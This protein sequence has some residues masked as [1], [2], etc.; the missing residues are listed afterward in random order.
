[1]PAHPSPKRPLTRRLTPSQ[2][3]ALLFVLEAHEEASARNL[4][5]CQFAVELEA[6]ERGGVTVNDLRALLEDGHLE[7]RLETTDRR[8]SRRTFQRVRSTALF[9][10]SCF[11]L[12]PAGLRC[13]T[14]I[15]SEP[16][17][18]SADPAPSA[19]RSGESV[20]LPVPFW[21]TQEKILWYDNR[22]LKRYLRPAP[23]QEAILREFQRKKWKH[24]VKNP[25]PR[26]HRMNPKTRLCDTLKHLNLR[27]D[28]HVLRFHSTDCGHFVTWS[29]TEAFSATR[30]ASVQ[31]ASTT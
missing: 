2:R 19:S 22:A 4:A 11:I 20:T 3:T 16:S 13:A 15:Q 24:R 29:R 26:A 10:R 21:D 27:P 30:P 1:M 12:T 17:F 25:L 8:S 28:L 6:L 9:T 31:P 14:R 23:N 18:R 7:H 5:D